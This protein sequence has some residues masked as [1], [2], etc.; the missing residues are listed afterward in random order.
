MLNSRNWQIIAFLLLMILPRVSLYAQT[1]EISGII[2]DENNQPMMGV[3][4]ITQGTTGQGTISDVNGKYNIF[5]EMNTT[6]VFSFIGY[7]TA[8]VSVISAE[9]NGEPA[10]A[11]IWPRLQSKPQR[12]G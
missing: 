7:K 5:T 8:E 1:T 6:L 11:T 10:R 12:S 9:I 3:N 2:M 4:V